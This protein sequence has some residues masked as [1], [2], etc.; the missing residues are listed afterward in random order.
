MRDNSSIKR[1]NISVFSVK[2]KNVRVREQMPSYILSVI[3]LKMTFPGLE[4]NIL[5]FQDFSRFP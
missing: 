5:K 4:I 1:V 2:L 3:L